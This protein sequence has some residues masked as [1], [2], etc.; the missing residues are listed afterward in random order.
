[1][2]IDNFSGSYR[3]LSNFFPARVVMEGREYPS[4]ENA[5]QAAK[6]LRLPDRANFVGCSAV[7][8]KRLGRQVVMR[9]DWDDARLGVMEHLLAEKFAR[10]SALAE[11]LL[12]T[13]EAELVEGNYWHDTFWGVCDGRGQNHLGR[14]LM[15]RREIL[16]G[17]S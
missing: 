6:C 16:R 8:A 11:R 7:Q 4:V 1:M 17:E 15:E 13:G 12:A 14:L 5:Y 9:P 3:F 10:S 2:R